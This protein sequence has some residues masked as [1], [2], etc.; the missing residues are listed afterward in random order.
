MGFYILGWR[1]QASIAVREGRSLFFS[2]DETQNGCQKRIYD[3][4]MI[5]HQ[6]QDP[7]EHPFSPHF[8]SYRTANRMAIPP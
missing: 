5:P 7:E 3:I 8:S 2:R 4:M 1:E 6:V